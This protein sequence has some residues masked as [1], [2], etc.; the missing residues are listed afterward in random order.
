MNGVK[1]VSAEKLT[2]LIGAIYDCALD[3]QRWEATCQQIAGLSKSTAGGI[4][5]HDLRHVQNNQLFVFGYQPEFLEMLENYYAEN[6]MA[7][8]DIVSNSG[9]VSA[10]SVERYQMLETRFFREV[11]KPFGLQD[12][13]WFPAMQT[14][15]RM[16][17]LHASRSENE[18]DFQQRD[19]T[20]FKLLSPHV[21]R[22]LAISDMLDTRAIRS[23]MLEKTLDGLVAGVFLTARDGHV[24]YLNHAAESQIKMGHAIHLVN[25]RIVPTDLAA[26]KALTKAM[27]EAA[28]DNAVRNMREH[29]VA[30]PAGIGGG[31]IAT[32]LPMENGQR[33]G[34]LASFAA[35]VAVFMQDPVQTTLM[36]GEAFARLHGLTGGELRVLLA[37]SQGLSGTEAADMLGIS[38]PTVRTHLQHIFSK[39]G[40]SKQLDLLR[41]LHNST[42]PIRALQT[43]AH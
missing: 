43:T 40:T 17:S 26:R 36:P 39:T 14:E 4:C 35:S 12:M 22:A 16:A 38:E 2:S 32:L 24:V 18:P 34:L 7:A 5:V 23:E 6:P 30:I 25:N 8:T 27:E 19:L 20:L 31:Y 1:G 41:L 10:F 13:V 37:L 33:H 11:L 28:R 9:G 42:P 29:F 21:C 3:P 15:G